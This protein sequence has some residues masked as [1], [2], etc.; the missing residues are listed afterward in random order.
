GSE[1]LVLR[2]VFTSVQDSGSLLGYIRIYVFV[3]IH[4]QLQNRELVMENE[5]LDK[6]EDNEAVRIWSEKTQLEKGQWD[7]G[8]KQLFYCH[9]G[10]LP[11]LLDIKVDEHLFRVLAQFWNLTYSCFTFRKVDLVPT[12]E[13]YTALLRC[14]RIQT[15]KVY[16]RAANVPTFLKKLMNITGMSEQWITARIKQKGDCRCIPWRNLRDLILAYP[17]MK[18]IA[19]VSALRIYGLV[20]F[21]K[22]LGYVDEIV[23]DLFDRLDKR[24]TPVPVILAEMLR[25]LNACRKVGEGRFIGA[26][27][28][29]PLLVL[30]QYK[31]RQF[32]PITQGLAQCE[33]SYKGDNYKKKIREM[34][35]AWNQNRRVKRLVVGPM[36][37]PK[38][39]EWWS[40]RINDN[41]RG[42]SQ[43]G[44]RSIEEHLRKLEAQKL[45]RGKN[46]AE[47]DLDSL[48]MD[49]KKLRTS[50]RTV[51][52]CKT[53]EE[54]WQEIQEKKLDDTRERLRARVA[55]LERSLQQYRSRNFAIKLRASLSKVEELKGRIEELETELQNC[56]L[57]VELLEANN[58]RWKELLHRSQDQVRE[59]DYIMGEAL[60]QVR[61]VANRLQTLA[62]QADVLSVKYELELDRGRE[63]DWLLRQVKALGIRARPYIY[64][65]TSLRYTK[66]NKINGPKV[67]KVGTDAKGGIG[68][69]ARET[70]QNPNGYEGANVRIPEEHDEP[71]NTA[72]GRWARKK[73]E[74]YAQYWRR[75]RGKEKTS[76]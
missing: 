18:K 17:D 57:W 61:D 70:N 30:K 55:K 1:K 43:E 31:S 56:E 33:F 40:K 66:E 2:E 34:S 5:F 62:A 54:W 75:Q 44:S 42:P 28:Y 67:G 16:S 32:M 68:S 24:V 23:P 63:L 60:T 65:G 12:I 53:S 25:S 52:L 47:E 48:K 45:R 20:V 8:I 72:T 50:I 64:P 19:D 49:S 36:T 13:E 35:N 27:G 46:K 29:A 58:E 6:V 69:N 4:V 74:P 7:D 51:D 26:I 22:A 11:Y 3:L 59:R 41:I 10:D 73:E 39:N 14:P 38:Y 21:P 9:Y 76:D 71:I 15:D 37:T